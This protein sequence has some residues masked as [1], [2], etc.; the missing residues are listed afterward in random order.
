MDKLQPETT[1]LL[2]L[3]RVI[4]AKA[5]S[6]GAAELMARRR[7]FIAAFR[8]GMEVNGRA[9]IMAHRQVTLMSQP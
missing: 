8:V 7:Q 2:C 6:Q 1:G 4:S 3:I 5:S 9:E